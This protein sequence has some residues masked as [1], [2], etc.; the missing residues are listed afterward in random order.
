[1]GKE[2]V[3]RNRLV[4]GEAANNQTKDPVVIPWWSG[5]VGFWG[6]RGA[7]LLV[8]VGDLS[9]SWSWSCPADVRD[10]GDGDGGW[11]G[12]GMGS[13]RC[14]KMEMKVKDERA[15]ALSCKVGVLVLLPF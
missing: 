7:S 6:L 13:F 3:L 15:K 4:T 12:M 8:V 2:Q 10:D 5:V 11:D 9:R 1:M 14:W